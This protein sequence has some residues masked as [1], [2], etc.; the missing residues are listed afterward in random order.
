[1]LAR[2]NL[3][4][5]MQKSSDPL[6]FRCAFKRGVDS[7]N[8]PPDLDEERLVNS[9][10]GPGPVRYECNSSFVVNSQ[11]DG[12]KARVSL[13]ARSDDQRLDVR[14]VSLERHA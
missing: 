1:M 11:Q 5:V 10:V 6:S 2:T 7:T 4:A 3:L 12:T 9:V 13:H 14:P 8:V